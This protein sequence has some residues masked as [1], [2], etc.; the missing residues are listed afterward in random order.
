M[1]TSLRAAVTMRST[2]ET[3]YV[4]SRSS[5]SDDWIRF[6][7]S[8]DI[9][10]VLVPATISDPVRYIQQ[11][12]CNLLILT[13]GEDVYSED[14]ELICRSPR[15]N[16]EL[17][18]LKFTQQNNRNI[19]VLG[20]CRGAQF[21]NCYFGGGISKVGGHVA[22]EHVVTLESELS[23]V[24][25]VDAAI[26]VNSYHNYSIRVNDLAECFIQLGSTADG[27]VELFGHKEKRIYGMVWHPERPC[28][29]A[30]ATKR[31][32]VNFLTR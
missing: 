13:N 4:E 16:V 18:L 2:H 10:Y 21:L 15:D 14:G 23:L 5:I 9:E 27:C 26:V 30:E 3:R 7:E 1:K 28:R 31:I 24:A 25:G 20:V 19:G 32:I 22:V 8:L 29:D 17:E 11:Q 12:G 6:F